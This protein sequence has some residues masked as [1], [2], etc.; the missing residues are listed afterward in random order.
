V[1]GEHPHQ[2][3]FRAHFQKKDGARVLLDLVSSQKIQKT[4][5][6]WDSALK[7]YSD[8]YSDIAQQRAVVSDKIQTALQGAARKNIPFKFWKRCVG[9][10]WSKQPLS[11]V[12]SILSDPG[13]RFNIGDIDPARFPQFP[14][15]YLA[16]DSK[17]AVQET[18]PPTPHPK[19]KLSPLEMSLTTNESFIVVSVCGYMES[20]IDL[21]DKK[22]LAPFVDIIK[23]FTVSAHLFPTAKKLG[24]RP[25]ELIVDV[26][27]LVNT[28]L[29]PDW[30]FEPIHFDIPAP[31]QIFGRLIMDSGIDG[32]LFPSKHTGKSCLAVFPKNLG[33]SPSWVELEESHLPH[34]TVIKRLDSKTWKALSNP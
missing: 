9:W 19:G 22:S 5:A 6:W 12:G 2:R 29:F 1:S 24:L 3:G 21:S 17:T 27:R 34:K 28:L 11:S 32:I 8:F 16:E 14:A 18:F 4:K 7:Y 31:S 23:N 15:L 13:G 33:T 10:R 30:K 20:V 25:P 26:D